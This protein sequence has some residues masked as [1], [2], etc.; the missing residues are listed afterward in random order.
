MDEQ[1]YEIPTKKKKLQYVCSSLIMKAN[2][3]GV[4]AY[5]LKLWE[6]FVMKQEAAWNM[7]RF[8]LSSGTWNSHQVWQNVHES[9]KEIWRQ[10]F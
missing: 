5:L 7:F 9:L 10:V 2:A 4:L 6:M 8:L 1:I 3:K